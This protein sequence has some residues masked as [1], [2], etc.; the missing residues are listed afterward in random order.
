MRVLVKIAIL[1]A[2]SLCLFHH[3]QSQAKVKGSQ[4]LA[5]KVQQLLDMNAKRP[6]MRFNGNRFRDFV[7][8]APRNYSVVIM[9]TAMAPARQ[10]VICRHAHDEYTIVA[11]SYRYSQTYSNKLF[12]AMVD[13]DEG[14][15]VFQLLRLNTAPVFIHFPAK[16]KPKPADTMD[17]QRVGVSAEVIGKWIQERTDIQIRIFRPPNYSA[18]VAILMLTAFVGGFLYLRRNN[19][20]FLYNKQMWGFLAVIFCFAMVSG[21]MWNHIRSPPFVHKG[22]N[23]GIAYIHGS[24]QGQLVIETYIVMFLNAMIVAG[25]IL[26]TESG[27]QSDPRK[28]KIAA[29]V[30]L[31]LVAVFF[32]L[33]LSIF[34]SKAQGYPYSFLF[35]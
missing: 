28:G 26:L 12:F 16:G 33:I 18:T 9:F 35:K 24:S 4:T 29:V 5:E 2:I 25:M 7:K 8:S 21:Q 1:V 3:V 20:D 11:N 31:V 34:R 10:C 6:V 15:D 27:S 23:G 30:G 13:F 19:L 32:S 22:Q 17:I 14:S